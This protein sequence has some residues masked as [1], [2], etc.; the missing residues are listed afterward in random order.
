MGWN[1]LSKSLGAALAAVVLSGCGAPKA[2]NVVFGIAAQQSP[3]QILPYLA[4][5][6]GLFQKSG[7]D[8]RVEEFAGSSKA[9]EALIG[10]SLDGSA[11]RR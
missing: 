11:T 1:K 8:V 10:G 9:M 5:D 4:R 2:P 3:S 6:L 7:L